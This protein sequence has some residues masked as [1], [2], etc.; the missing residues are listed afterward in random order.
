VN[1]DAP[2]DAYPEHDEHDEPIPSRR[3]ESWRRRSAIG[4]MATG[5]ARG[6]Q[7]VFYPKQDQPVIMA[8][9]PGDP[10]DADQRL[11]V[12]LDPDDPAKSVAII[13]PDRPDPPDQAEEPQ[14]GPPAA[15]NA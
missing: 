3:F 12:V 13:P 15:G 6:L 11:R 2:E 1:D 8:E 14:G 4:S 5:I 10:P 9:A 7:D